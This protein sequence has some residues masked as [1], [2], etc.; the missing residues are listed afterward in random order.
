MAFESVMAL[1]ADGD[2]Y[3]D[4]SGNIARKTTHSDVVCQRIQSTLRLFSGEA[5]LDDTKGVPYYD[6]ILKKNPDLGRIRSLL[7]SLITGVS[8]VD[9]INSLSV[10][11]DAS[12]REYNLYFSC[13]ADDGSTVEGSV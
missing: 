1:N 8:G 5:Y 9:K 7:V 6:E 10:D 4:S 3:L 12:S 2:I 13:T 11:F